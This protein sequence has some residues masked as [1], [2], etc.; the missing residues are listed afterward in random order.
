MNMVNLRLT[1]LKVF[2]PGP[3]AIKVNASVCELAGAFPVI[4]Q[5]A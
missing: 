1:K 2:G 4:T 5:N 3:L